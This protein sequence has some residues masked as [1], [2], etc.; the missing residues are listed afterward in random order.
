LNKE[1]LKEIMGEIREAIPIG[2]NHHDIPLDND[3]MPACCNL[4]ELPIINREYEKALYSLG[5]LGGGNHFIEIQKGSDGFIWIMLHSGSRNLGKQVA[6][7]YN[8]I[9]EEQNV[10]W[11]SRVPTE[12]ELA[13]LPLDS[14]EGKSYIREM[15]FCIEYAKIN[16]KTMMETIKFIFNA[17]INCTF[18]STI[19]IAHNYARM[20]NHFDKNVLVHRKGA[21][22]AG[23][24]HIGIIP[25]S[26]GTASYTVKGKGNINSFNS[27]SHGAGRCMG[28]KEAIR[29]LNLEQEI[30]S[31]ND[32]GIIHSIRNAQD[33]EEAP[34]AYKNIDEVMANQVDLIDILIELKPLAVIK[35]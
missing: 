5:T 1:A 8:K 11:I 21:T 3:L 4:S 26:Q 31:L 28:R 29:K 27:C 20:E 25:G 15:N 22:F 13:F 34:S 23:G 18:D 19:D 6:D 12:F 16:R 30:K 2:F 7:Y 9:A 33:L 10:L 35:G 17:F 14:D 32:L 24:G